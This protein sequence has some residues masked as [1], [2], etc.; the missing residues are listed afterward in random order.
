MNYVDRKEFCV[1]CGSANPATKRYYCSAACKKRGRYSN[2]RQRRTGS[3][4]SRQWLG[5]KL[6]RAYQERDF[7]LFMS[8][9][10]SSSTISGECWLWNG[11]V[12][13]KGYPQLTIANRTKYLHRV[14]WEVAN[15][16]EPIQTIHHACAHSMC[17]NP[18]HLVQATHRDNLAEMYARHSYEREIAAL[19]ARVAE[20]EAA[21]SGRG[22]A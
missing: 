9:V 8:L 2:R 18:Q 4:R 6:S 21:L 10:R 22:A 11:S 14:V 12:S 1:I 20:L 17:V 3:Y 16:H 7:D 15:G 13:M 19:K 5:Q